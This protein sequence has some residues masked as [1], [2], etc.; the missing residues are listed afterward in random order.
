MFIFL[1]QNLAWIIV[2]LLSSAILW[3]V[4]T[5]QQDYDVTE[6]F[7][8][9]PVEVRNVPPGLVVRSD[10]QTVRV[11]VT[12][13]LSAQ[14]RLTPGEFKAY[15]DASKAGAGLQ[16]LPVKIETDVSMAR[17]D[18]I[19]PSKATVAMEVLKKK[20]VPI[21]LSILGSVPFGYTAGQAKLT[22]NATTVSGP[23][24]LVEEVTVASIEVRLDGVK[25]SLNQ[26]FK[27]TALNADG[28]EVKG[29]TLT[30]DVALVELPIEQQLAYKT[31]PVT[32][33]VVGSVALGYQ[34]VG[35]I[36]DP[37]SVTVVGDPHVLDSMNYLPT[38]PLD[39]TGATKDVTAV[40]EAELQPGVSLA[41]PQSI[42]TRVFVS[43]VEC[44]KTFEAAV[45][46]VNMARDLQ[47]TLTPSEVEVTVSGP[48]PVLATM[49]PT[50]I[51]IVL[52]LAGL[53]PGEHEV[54]PQVRV[55]DPL[56][57]DR[58]SP[59]KIVVHLERKPSEGSPLSVPRPGVPQ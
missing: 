4:V 14:Q 25:E 21:K 40:V 28:A 29:V 18:D 9:L 10:P 35:I 16:Q 5:V 57:I 12:A 3:T 50:D 34:I 45:T 58:L 41:R 51:E 30:P 36:V 15:V 49:K 31:V 26:T 7:Y 17:I 54:V 13:P 8:G 11:Q 44:S 42:V 2:S 39:V 52:D 47:M 24:S 59:E 48:M 33:Q 38:Q 22:P 56:R 27:L 46:T 43:P 1:K 19:S 55:P 6:T 23:Q 53:G 32:P 20:D 37:T